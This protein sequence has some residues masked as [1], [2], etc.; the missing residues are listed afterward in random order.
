MH[1]EYG[2]LCLNSVHD[3]LCAAVSQIQS[4]DYCAGS[5]TITLKLLVKTRLLAISNAHR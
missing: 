4:N 1:A 3:V 5:N 2:W